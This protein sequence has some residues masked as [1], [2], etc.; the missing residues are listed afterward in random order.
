MRKA[1]ERWI[2][3]L[4]CAINGHARQVVIEEYHTDYRVRNFKGPLEKLSIVKP[5]TEARI[6]CK[7][8]CRTCGQLGVGFIVKD[9]IAVL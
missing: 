8:G 1:Y 2:V 7:W 4:N 5:F 9:A 3:R 6:F